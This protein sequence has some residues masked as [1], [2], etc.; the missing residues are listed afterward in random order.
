MSI[1]HYSRNTRVSDRL[2]GRLDTLTRG[3]IGIGLSA[4]LGIAGGI[5]GVVIGAGT[6]PVV[7]GVAGITGVTIGVI[8]IGE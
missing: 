4:V 2:Y 7:L 1:G 3:A 5:A 6:W 8:W